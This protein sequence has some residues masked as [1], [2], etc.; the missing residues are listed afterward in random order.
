[1]VNTSALTLA[2]QLDSWFYRRHTKYLTQLG[3]KSPSDEIRD[4][5][6]TQG[7]KKNH[8]KNPSSMQIFQKTMY[9]T[10]IK[11]SVDEEFSLICSET[12]KKIIPAA[13]RIEVINRKTKAAW[14]NLDAG[15]RDMVE[16]VK[17]EREE[18]QKRKMIEASGA[19]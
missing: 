15:E 14:E 19:M 11:A 2:Q 4:A 12:G 9:L 17:V 18:E 16:K 7:G 13:K 10:H 1:L 5:E 8:K 3:S 6:G